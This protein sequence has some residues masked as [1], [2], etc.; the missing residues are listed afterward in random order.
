MRDRPQSIAVIIPAFRAAN[1]IA[2]VVAA[3]PPLVRHIVVVNDA[4]PD[5]L[6]ATLARVADPRMVVVEHPENRGVG[7]AMKSGFQRAIDLGA[8]VLVK[9]DADGQM[10]PA[11]IPLFVDPISEGN[12]DMTK[13]NRFGDLRVIRRMPLM[14]RFGNLVLS[15]LVKVASGYWRSFDPCNG[16]IALRADLV[17]AIDQ[18]RLDDRYFFEISLLC[19][20]WFARARVTEVPMVPVYGSEPSSLSPARSIPGFARRLAQRSVRRI[21]S[22]YFLRDF[23]VISLLLLTGLPLLVFGVVWSA[24]HWVQSARTEVFAS[25]GTVMIGVLA[26]VMGFQLLLQAIVLDV[27]NEPGRRR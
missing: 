24:Y 20:V 27:D 25:T 11:L 26:I 8:D 9:L 5:D 23:G 16:Y 10:D 3:V 15:F 17:R 1:S 2:A 13:G 18:R 22:A 7:G 21:L 19:E 6:A 4:S 12:A 14:R